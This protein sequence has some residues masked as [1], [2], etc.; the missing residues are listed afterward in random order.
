[1]KKIIALAGILWL[2]V[3]YSLLAEEVQVLGSLDRDTTYVD[4]EVVLTVRILG[5]GRN[6]QAP[7]LPSYQGFDSFYTGRTS[8][9]TF[10]N[11]KSSTTLEFSYVLVPKV[12]GRYTLEPVQVWIEGKS[13]RTQPL[14]VEVLGSQAGPLQPPTS[15]QQSSPSGVP[16]RTAAAPAAAP[17]TT[18]PAGSPPQVVEDD[19]LF[20][21]A[22]TDKQTAYPNEQVLLTYTLYTRYD[23]RYEGFEE[24][25]AV[26]G[27]W[28]E[29]FPLGQ[30]LGRDTVTVH[31]RRY[32]KAD[33]RRIALF[34]TAPA[35][36]TI[37]PGTLK[38]SIREE[39]K[40]SS[41]FDEFFGDSFF[42]GAGFFA[43]RVERLLKPKPIALTVRPFPET[44]K[45][46]NFNG[47]V[48][49]FQMSAAV[50]KNEV[51]QNEPV[52]LKLTLTGEG[53]IETLS[54]PPVP[55]L[56]GFK[57]YDGDSST[58]FFK[59]G[60]PVIAGR[61]TFEVI[62]IP[63]EAGELAVPPV[64]FSFFDPRREKYEVLNS[65]PFPLRVI[66][67]NEPIRL[68]AGLEEKE[69]FKKDIR[70]EGQDI[71]YIHEEIPS[72]K[73]AKILRWL[74][75]GL[76]GANLAGF[77]LVAVG[78]WRRREEALLARD[79]KLRRRKLART[80]AERRLKNLRKLTAAR[81]TGEVEQFV[82]EAQKVLNEYFSNQFN[83]SSYS[84]TKE[85]LEEKLKELWGPEDP[86]V[87]EIREFYEMAG[88]SRFGK[89]SLLAG[90]RR[91][92]I[93]LIEKVI[94]R[95]ER[96]R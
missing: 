71:R 8:Q 10:V 29:D 51:K 13:F 94:R 91:E 82:E 73:A 47:A 89:G 79:V 14:Q 42:S 92:F 16:V 52:T 56:T 5:S 68:P 46:T 38:V 77:L 22:L 90:E 12:P 20:V 4:E 11:G 58:E 9:Y 27:F 44:G 70:K 67:S 39:P 18:Q 96:L 50:D 49:Q 78:L 6:V 19:N 30:D 43:R 86:M 24:E 93:D 84:F 55:E 57:V 17:L 65:Q 69:A 3:S 64:A 37:Q 60:T 25:P 63:T 31:G 35:S 41:V 72:E 45:P 23:T 26:S 59:S 21:E 53:N 7:R 76:A 61:K 95:V 66:P 36:Y 80:H 40:S 81:E 28:I 15:A 54:R 62:F 33:I 74:Y 48:G 85:W 83:I 2:A 88:E 75:R 87:R 32:M 1:M 34:P